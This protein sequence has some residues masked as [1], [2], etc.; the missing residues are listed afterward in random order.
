MEMQQYLLGVIWLVVK[1]LLKSFLRKQVSM[2]TG[3][4]HKTSFLEFFS[5]SFKEKWSN[6]SWFTVSAG[7]HLKYTYLDSFDT[8]RLM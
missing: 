2:K 8:K 4:N 1:D 5:F 7:Q 6:E 3:N